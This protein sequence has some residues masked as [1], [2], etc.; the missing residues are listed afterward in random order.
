MPGGRGVCAVAQIP[1]P[2]FVRLPGGDG[3]KMKKM[4]DAHCS[5]QS[6]VRGADAGRPVYFSG[7]NRVPMNMVS[8]GH[9]EIV[10]AH[11]SLKETWACV[12]RNIR[13]AF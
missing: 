8:A 12:E 2:F 7:K 1:R 10:P 4:D 5:Y 3:M 6:K 9:L 11:S 13:Q